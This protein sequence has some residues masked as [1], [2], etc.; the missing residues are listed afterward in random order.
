MG[1]Y[2]SSGNVNTNDG[3][4]YDGSG[5]SDSSYGN[6]NKKVDGENMQNTELIAKAISSVLSAET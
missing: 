6:S 2:V 1:E 5:Y 3:F 4:G